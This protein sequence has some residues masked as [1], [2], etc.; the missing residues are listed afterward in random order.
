M[1]IYSHRGGRG[2]GPDNT[3]E[4]MEAAASAGVLAIE[5]DVRS[6]ADGELL[7]SHDPV[8]GRFKVKHSDFAD[9]RR[10]HPDRPLL[11]EVLGALAGRVS[12]NIEIKRAPP[13][14]VAEMVE[15]FKILEETVFSS[16]RYEL[17]AELKRE[18]PSARV[19]PLR[20]T[21]LAEHLTLEWTERTGAELL[22][23]HYKNLT[24]ENVEK[25]HDAGLEVY[26]WT[27]NEEAEVRRLNSFGVD[28]LITD[29]YLDMVEFLDGGGDRGARE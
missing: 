3:L 2:F 21:L 11:R 17:L 25:M 15:S 6:T 7:I 9:I 27:V 23:L 19:G 24:P 16:F 12:F 5:T 13:V 22:A 20:W 29:R 8:V 1:R 14:A 26:A 10:E 4:A 18:R 28:V